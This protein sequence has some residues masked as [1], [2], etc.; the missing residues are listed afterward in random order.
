[1]HVGSFIAG[2][3][4]VGVPLALVAVNNHRKALAY[5]RALQTTIAK[6]GEH[7]IDHVRQTWP[8]VWAW[9]KDRL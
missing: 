4:I 7:L 1:M 5:R 8:K 9:L 3:V 6:G 2:A